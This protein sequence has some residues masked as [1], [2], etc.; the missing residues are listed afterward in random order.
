M[1]GPGAL[2]EVRRNGFCPTQIGTIAGASGGAK[3]LVLSQLDRVII[4]KVLPKLSAPVHLLGS[5]IGAWRFTC[6]AQASP[7]AALERLESAYLDQEYSQAPHRDEI[8]TVSRAILSDVLGSNGAREILAN[9]TL[10]SHFMTVRCRHL[11]ATEIQPLLASGLLLAALANA[12]NRRLLGAF[13]SRALFHDSRDR[14][15]FYDAGGFPLDRVALT[16]KNLA[17]VVMASGAIP[18]LLS[19]VRNIDGAPR[20]TYRDGGVIDYHL[21]LPLAKTGKLTLFPHFFPY[22]VPGWF[23]KRHAWRKPDSAHTDRTI[24]ICPAPEFVAALPGGKIPDRH[25]FKT[26]SSEERKRTWRTV[27][28][29]CRALADELNDALDN[30]RLAARLQPL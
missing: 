20:G 30:D 27:V 16:E 8:T 9:P 4:E 17:D 19:G 23:D 24:L 12:L 5:S 6:Y 3:W 26:M 13:F 22:L 21:D 2:N 18:L 29:T 11:T 7:L 10:R 15:P 25:D 28:S 14:P 1:A